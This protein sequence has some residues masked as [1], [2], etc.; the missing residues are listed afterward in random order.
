[1]EMKNLG[2]NKVYNIN[3]EGIVNFLE[4]QH[5]NSSSPK[6]KR[7]AADYMNKVDCKNVTEVD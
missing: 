4:E 3:F 5:K 7:W 6:L 2:L 1:M